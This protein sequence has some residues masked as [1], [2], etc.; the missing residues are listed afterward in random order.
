MSMEGF[1]LFVLHMRAL[2]L[3]LLSVFYLLG[4]AVLL[5][6]W[7]FRVHVAWTCNP[8]FSPLCRFRFG[9]NISHAPLV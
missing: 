9:F 3:S 1:C 4:V 6:M 2:S 8:L 7:S 5:C